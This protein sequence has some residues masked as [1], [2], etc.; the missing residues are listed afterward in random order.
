[1]K[2]PAPLFYVFALLWFADYLANTHNPAELW[3]ALGIA[4][5]G[6]LFQVWGRN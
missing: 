3:L 4:G 1:M 2:N 5:I 6:L